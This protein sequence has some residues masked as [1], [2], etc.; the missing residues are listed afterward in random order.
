MSEIVQVS[1]DLENFFHS[2]DGDF[3]GLSKVRTA[4]LR[5]AKKG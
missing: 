5:S 3:I 1:S 2:L 4:P